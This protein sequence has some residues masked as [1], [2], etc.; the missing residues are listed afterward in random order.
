M[1]WLINCLDAN[2]RKQTWAGNIADLIANHLDPHGWLP[3]TCG[4]TDYI[5]C[6]RGVS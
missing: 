3:C 1:G 6:G 4:K 2:C 5:R